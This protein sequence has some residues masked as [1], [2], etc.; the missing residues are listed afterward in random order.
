MNA[1]YLAELGFVYL[2]LGFKRSAQG[3]FERSLKVSPDNGKALEG[4]KRVRTL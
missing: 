2:E 4:L 1:Q 3:F